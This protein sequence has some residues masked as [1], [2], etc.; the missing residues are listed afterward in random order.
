MEFKHDYHAGLIM[1]KIEELREWQRQKQK[2]LLQQQEEQRL[3]LTCEHQRMYD[4]F[5]LKNIGLYKL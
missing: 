5:G 4:A 3:L 1:K 2:K